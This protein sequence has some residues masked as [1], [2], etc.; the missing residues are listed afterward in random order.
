MVPYTPHD[1]NLTV[2]K[3]LGT[4]L[5]LFALLS[6]LLRFCYFAYFLL[7]SDTRASTLKTGPTHIVG[8][9]LDF[10]ATKHD[11]ESFTVDCFVSSVGA[12][13]VLTFIPIYFFILF[14]FLCYVN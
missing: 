1:R 11:Y 2:N 14:Y 5:P 13:E 9:L 10:P 8:T 4:Y 6:L 12:F 3:S 7:F